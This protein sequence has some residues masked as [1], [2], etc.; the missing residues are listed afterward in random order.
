MDGEVRAELDRLH[1]EEKRQNHRLENCERKLADITDLTVAVKELALNSK[2]TK[3]KVEAI[4]QRLE[5]IE[6]EPSEAAKDARATIRRSVITFLAGALLMGAAWL[7]AN[8][9]GI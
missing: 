7:I 5:S 4:D 8:H 6:K 2:Y 9:G 3:E 1:D